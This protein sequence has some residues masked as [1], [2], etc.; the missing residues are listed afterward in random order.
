M[1]SELQIGSHVNYE[2]KTGL[3]GCVETTLQNRANALMFYTGAPQ[4][5]RRSQINLENVVQ[6][7]KKLEQHQI[8]F[9]NVIVHAPY[10]INLANRK[11]EEKWQFSIRFLEE[12]INRVS[13]F[14]FSY[15]VLHPG[16][17]VQEG[18]S[19][20]ISNIIAALNEVLENTKEKKV[21]IL[22]ETMAG[23][24]TEIG[25]TIEELKQI[26]EGVKRKERIG[27]CL[28]TCHLNDAGYDMTSFDTFLDFFETYFPLSL[29]GCIHLNDSKNE[30][31]SHKDR[32]ENIGFG[33]LGFDT[34][35]KIAYNKR[36][37]QVP[38]ILETPYINRLYSPYQKEIAML[39]EKKFCPTLF[40]EEKKKQK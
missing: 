20:G 34:L 10:I 37:E 22:L 9:S 14:G 24:G 39:H 2:S 18:V 1:T 31:G 16:S 38:K 28:D 7:K 35:L 13:T 5:T 4:N 26:Y 30:R 3:L 25:K 11:E 21:K 12:E 32:H 23:K 19:K 29:I 6:A 8:P 36:L 33:T 17:H 27:I 15:L 40:E